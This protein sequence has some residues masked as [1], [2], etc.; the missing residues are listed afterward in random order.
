MGSCDLKSI[1][2]S[3]TQ[4]FL[5]VDRAE[6]LSI[7]SKMA[8]PSGSKMIVFTQNHHYLILGQGVLDGQ[9]VMKLILV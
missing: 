3:P 5:T 1:T 7:T 8:T 6:K 4:T 2:L 9:D